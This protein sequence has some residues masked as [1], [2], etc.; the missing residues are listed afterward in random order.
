[1]INIFLDTTGSMSEMGKNSGA[2]YIVKSIQDYCEFHNIKT[3]LYK[4]DGSHIYNLTSL[5][6][7]DKLNLNSLNNFENSI[8]VSDGLLDCEDE[9]LVDVSIS[10]GIDCDENNLS[11]IA[12]KMFESDNTIASLEYLLYQANLKNES[13]E[14]E[15]ED[16]W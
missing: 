16:E 7:N 11:K 2:I 9:N 3:S 1:M 10:V 5:V 6:F 13:E 14:I 12:K 8:I 4:L 15:D